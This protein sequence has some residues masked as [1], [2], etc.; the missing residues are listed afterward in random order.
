MLRIHKISTRLYILTKLQNL[1]S[2]IIGSLVHRQKPLQNE[3]AKDES[4]LNL[5]NSK[6]G[7]LFRMY[8][9]LKL[10]GREAVSR[11]RFIPK[12]FKMQYSVIDDNKIANYDE[13]IIMKYWNST[14]IKQTRG[15]RLY[16]RLRHGIVSR[17]FPII[18][19]FLLGHY[20]FFALMRIN[21]CPMRN[22]SAQNNASI[23]E[24]VETLN[25]TFHVRQKVVQIVYQYFN[26]TNDNHLSHF[27]ANLPPSTMY[28]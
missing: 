21:I 28:G 16:K 19:L 6:R 25:S 11:S 17:T 14:V 12:S 26:S 1:L 22:S 27:C 20:A 10:E 13:T 8:S 3:H 2:N 24:N 23:Y 7:S 5:T 18:S 9:G 4:Q 15:K